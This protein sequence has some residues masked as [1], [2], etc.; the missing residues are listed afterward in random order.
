ME[1]KEL[2]TKAL[3]VFG[4]SNVENLGGA[5]M[6]CAISYDETKMNMFCDLVDNDLSILSGGT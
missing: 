3:Q 2:T 6:E 1:L 4:V 5:L